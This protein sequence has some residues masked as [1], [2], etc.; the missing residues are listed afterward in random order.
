MH[1]AI[2]TPVRNEAANLHR[3]AEAVVSQTMRPETWVLVE[4]GSTDETATVAESLARDYAWISVVRAGQLEGAERGAPIIKA[5]HIGIDALRPLPEVV[6]QLDADLSFAEDYFE[7]L[8]RVLGASPMLGIVSGT[9]FE[10]TRGEWHRKHATG[11]NVWGAARL[12]RRECLEQVL[13]LELRTGWDAIDVAEATTLGWETRIL[14]E[15]RFYHHRREASREP[16]R[17]SAWAAQGR[18]SHYLGYRPSYLVL[19]ALFK[20]LRDPA[21]L[22]LVAGY[23]GA[24]LRRAEQC[25]KPGL[26]AHVREQQRVRNLHLRASEALGKALST[27]PSGR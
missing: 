6:G 4:N 18:V 22:A 16:T 2:V 15:L 8:L 14:P 5:F 13:P 25:R 27:E 10:Q 19:R 20:S 24:A 3:V 17:W 23:T 1:Y 7:Q 11:V 21:A 26:I 9:C 12:Y